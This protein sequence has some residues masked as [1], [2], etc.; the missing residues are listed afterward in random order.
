[1]RGFFYVLLAAVLMMGLP[2]TALGAPTPKKAVCAVCG[3]RDGSGPEPVAAT[4]EYQGKTYY[5]CE[6]KCK[7]EFQQDP[8]KWVKLAQEAKPKDEHRHEGEKEGGAAA[9][10]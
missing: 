7:V 5:F 3:P 1:M 10:S 8:E 4:L 2:A 6:E 9:P